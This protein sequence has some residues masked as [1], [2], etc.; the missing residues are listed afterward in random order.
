M[1]EDMGPQK[2]GDLDREQSL[3]VRERQR[4]RARMMGLVLGAL[5]ILF[6]AVTVAKIGVW[7]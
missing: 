4:A 2:I 5:C 1:T 6:F 7:G 3:L